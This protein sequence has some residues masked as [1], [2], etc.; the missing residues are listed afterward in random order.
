MRRKQAHNR[1]QCTGAPPRIRAV[2]VESREAQLAR[3]VF[4]LG[5][6]ERR[7]HDPAVRRRLARALRHERRAARSGRAP[8]DPVRH[9]VLVRLERRARRGVALRRG[10]RASTCDA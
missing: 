3:R 1:T 8:Y 5:I 6:D 9:L 10:S 7:L 4:T 2:R